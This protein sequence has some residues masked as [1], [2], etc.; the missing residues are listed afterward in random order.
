MRSEQVRESD[1]AR[2]VRLVGEKMDGMM[3][4]WRGRPPYRI[5]ARRVAIDNRELALRV[6]ETIGSF[7]SSEPE[8]RAL[9]EV[10][11]P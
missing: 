5:A 9:Q 2:F 4:D 6:M 3:D 8:L 1:V 10:W 7:P 11:H